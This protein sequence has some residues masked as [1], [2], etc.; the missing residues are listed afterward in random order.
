MAIFVM[1]GI[2]FYMV[3]Y[4]RE[5]LFD[6][7]SL[8]AVFATLG[9]TLVSIASLLCTKYYDEFSSCINTFKNELLAQNINLNW[10]FLKRQE[11]IKKS[12]GEYVSYQASNPKVIFQLGAVNLSVEVPVQKKDFYGPKLLQKALQMK[13]SKKIY[14]AYLLNY[15]DTVMESGLYIWEC[16]YHILCSALSYKFYR[17][18]IITGTIFFV[19]GL[20]VTFLYPIIF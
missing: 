4:P 6:I 9:S 16:I 2:I 13:I 14:V 5:N 12:K 1:T 8:G 3:L 17:N 7:I 18:L 11:V 10:L 20:L 19:S 15:T